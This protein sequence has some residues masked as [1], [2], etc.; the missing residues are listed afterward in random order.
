MQE[1]Q[2]HKAT[3]PAQPFEVED[4]QDASV[5]ACNDGLLGCFVSS[6]WADACNFLIKSFT[7]DADV[8]WEAHSW[9]GGGGITILFRLY[10]TIQRYDMILILIRY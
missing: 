1:S 10:Y 7:D 6:D 4:T 9:R 8:N 2:S 3:G 5:A